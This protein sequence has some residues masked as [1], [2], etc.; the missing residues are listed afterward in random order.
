[1]LALLLVALAW[2]DSAVPDDGSPAPVSRATSGPQS[3]TATAGESSEGVTLTAE[4]EALGALLK[5]IEGESGIRFKVSGDLKDMP[6]SASISAPDWTAAVRMLLGNFNKVEIF[7]A[8]DRLEKVVV[9]GGNYDTE[10]PPFI[11]Y[12]A[13]PKPKDKKV[14]S[15]IT[16]AIYGA[17]VAPVALDERVALQRLASDFAPEETGQEE[18][19]SQTDSAPLKT[20]EPPVASVDYFDD[21]GTRYAPPGKMRA[22]GK[23]PD[24]RTIHSD[25]HDGPPIEK[26][27]WHSEEGPPGPDEY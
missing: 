3:E 20:L 12:G 8:N 22:R 2:P 27:A 4:K 21:P 10:N 11:G 17:G 23:G 7:D 1:M 6:I 16:A 13:E 18:A 5:R 24:P 19:L 25:A 26:A 9:M 14:T 15:W